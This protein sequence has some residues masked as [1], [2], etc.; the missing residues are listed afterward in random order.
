MFHLS[1]PVRQFDAC[2]AF[3]RDCFEATVEPLGPGVANLFVFGGQVT[4]HDRPASGLTDDLRRE[5][6]FGQV[7]APDAWTRSRERIA[8]SGYSPLRAIRPGEAPD[9]RGK[10]L[11]IDP[12]GNL[13][14]I[15]STA[16]GG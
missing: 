16:L 4:L 1:L 11:I 7:V 15:N 2:L 3:Y 10:L 6:H 14:E 5:M 8:A 13:V 9:G 12:S